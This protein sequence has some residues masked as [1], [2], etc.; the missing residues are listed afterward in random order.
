MVVKPKAHLNE[1]RFL[2][3]QVFSFSS[4]SGGEENDPEPGSGKRDKQKRVFPGR[5]VVWPPP[6]LPVTVPTQGWVGER[7]RGEKNP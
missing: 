6:L 7:E 2:L 3:T 4:L 1:T 5:Q